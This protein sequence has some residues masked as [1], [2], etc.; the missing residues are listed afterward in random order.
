LADPQYHHL[1]RIVFDAPNPAD[2]AARLTALYKAL[3]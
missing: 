3:G 2:L 1:S